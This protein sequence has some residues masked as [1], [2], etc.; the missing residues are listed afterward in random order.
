MSQLALQAEVQKE[1]V[2][3]ERIL[4]RF[5]ATCRLAQEKEVHV[6][7]EYDRMEWAS[8]AA[9]IEAKDK[10]VD[11]ETTFARIDTDTR[12]NAQEVCDRARVKATK[13]TTDGLGKSRKGH[14]KGSSFKGSK[15]PPQPPQAPDRR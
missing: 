6:A 3:V 15:G 11:P 13:E 8:L 14:S 4:R 2:S 9:R 1:S 12:R 10:S 7:Y 5:L